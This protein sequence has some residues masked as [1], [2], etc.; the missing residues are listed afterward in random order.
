MIYT[1]GLKSKLYKYLIYVVVLSIIFL[2]SLGIISF[3]PDKI[4]R[5]FFAYPFFVIG[6][7][8][9]NNNCIMKIKDRRITLLIMVL[10]LFMPVISIY[11]NG[12]VDL[13][14]GIF[15]NNTFMYYLWGIVIS[16]LVLLVIRQIFNKHIDFVQTLSNGTL[17]VLAYHKIVLYVF[18]QYNENFLLR[19][20]VSFFILII[21]YYPIKYFERFC[22]ILIGKT[23]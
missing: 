18:V 19:L 21:F 23:K 1:L 12:F 5:V 6:R 7:I 10:T 17:L 20:F 14:L 2:S 8:I 3:I 16:L 9:H 22:P 13:F 4:L 15:C 11:S